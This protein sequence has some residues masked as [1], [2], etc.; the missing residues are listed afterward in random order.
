MGLDEHCPWIGALSLH[1]MAETKATQLKVEA[2]DSFR[3]GNYANAVSKYSEAIAEDNSNAV[4]FANRAAC[5]N[6]LHK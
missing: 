3:K 1:A 5:Y 6:A 2:D 4:L